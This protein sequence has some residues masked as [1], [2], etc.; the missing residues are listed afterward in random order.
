MKRGGGQGGIY[1]I[2]RYNFEKNQ[3]NKILDTE[4]ACK[5]YIII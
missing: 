4:L 1:N 3:F 2:E 5:K